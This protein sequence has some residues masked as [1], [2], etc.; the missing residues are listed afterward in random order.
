MGIDCSCGDSD[1]AAQ[2]LDDPGIDTAF[3][4]PG[5]I[6]VPESMRR[7]PVRDAGS[8]GGGPEGAAHNMLC[9]RFGPDMIGEEPAWV[10]VCSPK[11][12]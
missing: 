11:V 1:V 3:E 10:A 4:K 6:A 7:D 12:A 2:D 5:R 9:D 8:L